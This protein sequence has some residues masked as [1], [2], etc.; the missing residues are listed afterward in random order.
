MTKTA[1]K[2][3]SERV[4]ASRHVYRGK[5]GACCCG[6]S[7]KHRYASVGR[8]VEGT[9]RGYAVKDEEV[10]DKYVKRIANVILAN[11]DIAKVYDTGTGCGYVSVVIDGIIYIAYDKR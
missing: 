4:L 7:G 11:L 10:N 9:K 5:D 3:I 8:K 2:T 1:E 6:C